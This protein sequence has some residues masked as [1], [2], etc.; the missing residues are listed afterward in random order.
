M[1][2]EFRFFIEE[3]SFL[4]EQVAGHQTCSEKF[5]NMIIICALNSSMQTI[6]VAELLGKLMKFNSEVVISRGC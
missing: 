4:K 6:V 5:I 3:K 1:Y 2:L